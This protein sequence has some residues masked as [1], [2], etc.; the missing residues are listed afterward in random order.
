MTALD[1]NTE[2]VEEGKF[3]CT[4]PGSL[5]EMTLSEYILLIAFMNANLCIFMAKVCI[6][7]KIH[8]YSKLLIFLLIHTLLSLIIIFLLIKP[9]YTKTPLVVPPVG[10]LG[11]F[12][13]F[14]TYIFSWNLVFIRDVSNCITIEPCLLFNNSP[15]S[16]FG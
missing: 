4:S 8:I 14:W 10:S 13:L 6:F 11:N 12:W 5:P 1:A 2:V 7:L 9:F 16:L 15:H 3:C